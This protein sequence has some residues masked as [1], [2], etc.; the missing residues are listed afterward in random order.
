MI[1]AA[2][3]VVLFLLGSWMELSCPIPLEGLGVRGKTQVVPSATAC[4][5]EVAAWFGS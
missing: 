1:I 3:V 5:V 4:P 2:G